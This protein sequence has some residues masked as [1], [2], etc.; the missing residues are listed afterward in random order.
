METIREKIGHAIKFPAESYDVEILWECSS[1]A[2]YLRE[3]IR[4]GELVLINDETGAGKIV[5]AAPPLERA[6]VAKERWESNR[7]GYTGCIVMD[8]AGAA[9]EP[10]DEDVV[11]LA[12][13][14]YEASGTPEQGRAMAAAPEMLDALEGIA[15]GAEVRTFASGDATIIPQG[16]LLGINEV[17][18]KARG[19]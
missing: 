18:K 6:D 8:V 16:L 4:K 7:P 2:T 10:Y 17:I 1:Q 14:D 12:R 3:R 5:S 11:I 13:L 9:K 15:K 19:K